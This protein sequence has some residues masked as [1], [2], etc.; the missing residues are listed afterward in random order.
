MAGKSGNKYALR[1]AFEPPGNKESRFC[2]SI[3]KSIQPS[4]AVLMEWEIFVVSYFSWHCF[5]YQGCS[6]AEVFL[7]LFA[8]VLNF[9]LPL[10]PWRPFFSFSLSLSRSLSLSFSLSLS[11]YPLLPQAH[12]CVCTHTHPSEVFLIYTLPRGTKWSLRILIIYIL[13]ILL[14]NYVHKEILCS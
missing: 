7:L 8:F 1:T 4:R 3:R 11:L 5:I 9:F 10:S 2:L 14:S 12:A 6:Q 13:Y